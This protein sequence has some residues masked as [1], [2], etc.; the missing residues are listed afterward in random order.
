MKSP[1]RSSARVCFRMTW[2]TRSCANPATAR[3]RTSPA[4]CF[5]KLNDHIDKVACQSCHIPEFARAQPTKMYWD[6]STAGQLMDGK[7]KIKGKDGKPAFDK[8]KGSFVWERN[9]V[10]EY[11]WFQRYVGS[12]HH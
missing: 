6:W 11:Y 2:A 10:P 7:A 4:A 3:N 5:T 12:C 9:V 1:P 8:K